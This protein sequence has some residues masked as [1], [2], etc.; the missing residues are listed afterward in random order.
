MIFFYL[1][2]A[3]LFQPLDIYAKSSTKAKVSKV[4]AAPYERNPY[5]D[6]DIWDR[7]TPYFLPADHPIRE[8]LDK[9]FSE[10]VTASFDSLSNAGFSNSFPARNLGVVVSKHPKINGFVLKIY[11]DEQP[12]LPEWHFWIKRIEGAKAVQQSIKRHGYSKMFKVPRKWIYPL[13][14]EPSAAEGSNRKNFIL[15]AENMKILKHD[16]IHLWKGPG[17][18]KQ[19]LDAIFT[20]IEEEGLLDSTWADNIPFCRDG[21]QAFVDLEHF[22]EWPIKYARM[23]DFLNAE[24]EIYW[25]YLVKKGG[26]V[27]LRKKK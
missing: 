27:S 13:P 19:R 17:M 7:L 23:G 10:R 1:L 21:K 8:T 22:Q 11:T 16:N 20:I 14:A 25:K 9:L 26:P 4:A 2:L 24:M 12:A 15:V 6:P 18:T 5:V 3:L